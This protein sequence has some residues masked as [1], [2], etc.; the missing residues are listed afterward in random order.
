MIKLTL[1][2]LVIVPVLG[3]LMTALSYN[4]GLL[5]NPIDMFFVFFAYASPAGINILVQA[6]LVDNC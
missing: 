6:Q 2:K 4:L 5:T 1:L 3:A